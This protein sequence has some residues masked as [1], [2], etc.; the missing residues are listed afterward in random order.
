MIKTSTFPRVWFLAAAVAL[1]AL[2][3][4][5]APAPASAAPAYSKV[6]DTGLDVRIDYRDN[7]R[8]C[9]KRGYRDWWSTWRSCRRA[10]GHVTANRACRDDRADNWGAR[11]CC[12]RGRHDWWSTQRQCRRAGGHV[13]YP[14]ACRNDRY[15]RPYGYNRY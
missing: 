15:N 2:A 12:Q 1:S 4:I 11:V 5:A 13:T 6:A 10:G 7:N 14:R 9:C 3:G 8:V